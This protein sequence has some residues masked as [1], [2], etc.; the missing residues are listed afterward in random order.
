MNETRE[1]RCA[2]TG[3]S[4]A[5]LSATC[6]AAAGDLEY[7]KCPQLSWGV[8]VRFGEPKRPE[9]ADKIKQLGAV[10]AVVTELTAKGIRFSRTKGEIP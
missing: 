3:V 6:Y 2:R 4:I 7:A 5:L 1:H 10:E 8:Y 9:R